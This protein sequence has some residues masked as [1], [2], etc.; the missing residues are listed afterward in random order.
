MSACFLFSASFGVV[1]YLLLLIWGHSPSLDSRL[2]PSRDSDSSNCTLR[3]PKDESLPVLDRPPRSYWSQVVGLL[4]EAIWKCSYALGTQPQ[5]Q[6]HSKKTGLSKLA[7]TKGIRGT[8][9]MPL[10]LFVSV[11]VRLSFSDVGTPPLRPYDATMQ[12]LAQE[13]FS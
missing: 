6:Q 10:A 3:F 12:G 11:P 7:V 4:L 2:R 8:F 9:K 13:R 5:T 1:V